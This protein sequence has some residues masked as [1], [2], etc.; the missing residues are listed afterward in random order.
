MTYKKCYATRLKG[1]KYKIHLWDDGGYDELEWTSFAYKECNEREKEVEGLRGESLKKVTKWEWK[2]EGIH[3]HDMPV[4]QKFL[5]ERFGTNSEVSKTVKEL[6]FDIECEIGGALTE[7]YIIKAPM[8]ITSIAWWDRNKDKWGI[9]ILDKDSKLN[10]KS[11]GNKDIIPCKSEKDL[12]SKFLETFREIDPDILVGYNSNYFDIPYLYYRICN[13]LGRD[14][15]SYLSPINEI[16]CKKDFEYWDSEQ[17]VQIIGVESLDYMLLHKKYHWRDEPSYALNFLGEKY[18]KLGKIEYIGNLNDLFKD[19][20]DKFILYN[21]RDVEILKELDLKFK[22]IA[23]TLNLSHKGKHNYSEVYKS[24]RTHD[25]AIS[26]YLL[27]QGIVPP[28]RERQIK[29]QYAGGYLFCP[30]AGL[31]NWVFDE[32]LTSLYPSILMS[33]NIGK[34][35]LVGRIINSDSRDNRKGLNDLKKLD[36]NFPIL[37]ETPNNSGNI[38]VKDLIKTIENNKFSITANGV[39]FRTDKKSVLSIVLN[40]W[41]NERVEYK[42]KMKEAYKKDNIKLGEYYYLMQYTMK[43]LLNSLYGA[44][45]LSGFRYGNVILAEGCTL[46]GQRIIQESALT[47]NRHMNKI[48]RKELTL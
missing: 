31:Y 28:S 5:I 10:I 45:A 39:M 47:V 44:L 24:S 46:T 20:I 48:I 41:F 37:M 7:E 35:T 40:Q 3:Y 4:H 2:E 25:G 21:F 19:D 8:P 1:N 17:Y 29:R 33:L 14:M 12:L 16:K 26:S 13:V 32:D 9:L 36:P 38:K 30:K 6:F 34:E 18:L 15:A 23:L 42:N 43:I 11:E 27:S 22:Y